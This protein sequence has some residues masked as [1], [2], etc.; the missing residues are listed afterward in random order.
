MGANLRN[1]LIM[2]TCAGTGKNLAQQIVKN[3]TSVLNFSQA[4]FDN[5][6][7]IS[8]VKILTISVPAL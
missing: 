4:D 3:F 8:S 2:R 5:F 7:T 6:L 1:R